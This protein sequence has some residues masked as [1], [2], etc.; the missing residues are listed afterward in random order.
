MIRTEK[1][2][3]IVYSKAASIWNYLTCTNFSMENVDIEQMKKMHIT[4]SKNDKSGEKIA[5][6]FKG[7]SL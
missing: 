5:K 2:E 7:I 4:E 3:E 6:L 1:K